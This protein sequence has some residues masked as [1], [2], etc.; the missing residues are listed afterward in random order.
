[1]WYFLTVRRCDY[2]I[3]KEL[4]EKTTTTTGLKVVVRVVDKDY[5]IGIKTSKEE[6]DY[7]R[8]KFNEIIPELSYLIAA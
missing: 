5:Q 7:N 1:V 8:I 6:L 4:V 3:V 2:N